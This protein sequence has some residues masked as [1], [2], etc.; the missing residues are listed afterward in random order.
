MYNCL[1]YA[2]KNLHLFVNNR[3]QYH[4]KCM[5]FAKMQLVS[6]CYTVVL[7]QTIYRL[8]ICKNAAVYLSDCIVVFLHDMKTENPDYET[9]VNTRGVI[10]FVQVLRGLTSAF[11]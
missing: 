1:L 3:K 11:L 2:K 6:N 7:Y 5:H 8:Y 4:A 9:S 10:L